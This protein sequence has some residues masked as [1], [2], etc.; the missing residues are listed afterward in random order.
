MCAPVQCGDGDAF[1]LNSA[2]RFDTEWLGGPSSVSGTTSGDAS[3]GTHMVRA[4]FSHFISLLVC[5]VELR[6]HTHTR[7]LVMLGQLQCDF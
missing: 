3:P 5:P 7:Q 1:K 6:A 2:C 4:P